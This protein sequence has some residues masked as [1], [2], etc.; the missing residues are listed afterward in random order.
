MGTGLPSI[1]GLPVQS[2]RAGALWD[3]AHAPRPRTPAG[4]APGLRAVTCLGAGRC[5][6]RTDQGSRNLCKS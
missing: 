6:V 2:A 3:S 5:T 1:Y 4:H